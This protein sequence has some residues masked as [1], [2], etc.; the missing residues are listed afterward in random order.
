[1]NLGKAIRMCRKKRGFT[2]AEFATLAKISVSHLCLLEKDKRDPSLS[3]VSSISDALKVP[4]SVLVLLASRHEDITELSENQIEE[5]S[6]NI[7]EIMDG[8]DKQESLF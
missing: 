5:L 4:V 6:R 3:V 7:L 1:M 2:Q 8:A